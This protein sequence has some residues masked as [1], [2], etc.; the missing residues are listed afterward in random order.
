[1][2]NILVAEDNIVM[3]KLL[4]KRLQMA[5]HEVRMASN[6][7]EALAL[8]E[9]AVADLILSDIAM[10]QMDGL[11]LLRRVRSDQ[12]FVD[13][14]FVLLTTSVLDQHRLE[15]REGGADGYL[16]KPVS[17]WELDNH[18]QQPAH[19][20]KELRAPMRVR[21][22][23]AGLLSGGALLFVSATLVNLGN[24]IFNLLLGRWLGPAAFA[25]LSL[26]VTLFLVTTFLA[27]GLQIPTARFVAMYTADGNPQ[28]IANLR[29]WA[30]K[31]AGW[32]GV[33]LAVICVVGAPA[34]SNFF[35][36]AS[37]WP[38]VIFGLFVPF[39]LLQGVDRGVLQGWTRFPRLAVTY[40]AEMWS[41]LLISVVLVGIGLGVNGAVLA[42]GLSFVSSMVVRPPRGGRS[43]RGRADRTGA[44]A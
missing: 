10:P 8:L 26:I 19:A 40:Q 30:L 4:T 25:D 29:R 32:I 12:R 24:Y 34:W 3:Q 11:T 7:M 9:A 42:I 20:R 6:G 5:G 18:D 23:M 39:Y 2:G 14:P 31:M 21:H 27:A 37:A 16:Q 13:V 28:T 1:M 33:V 35:S 36:T 44:A 41:R 38:F 43:P 22:P 15:A 17:S